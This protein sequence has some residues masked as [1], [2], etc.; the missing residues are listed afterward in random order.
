MQTPQSFGDNNNT[1]KMES[2]AIFML[3]IE[4]Q[5]E[6]HRFILNTLTVSQVEIISSHP[7]VGRP[8]CVSCTRVSRGPVRV[9]GSCLRTKDERIMTS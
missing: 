7:T 3:T 9:I 5:P 8:H 1:T 6:G 2:D 4:T